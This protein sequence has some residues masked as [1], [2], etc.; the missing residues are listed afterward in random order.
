[1]Q[2]AKLVLAARS[3]DKLQQLCEE[4]RAEGRRRGW[5]NAHAPAY[6]YLDLA[7]IADDEAAAHA[8]LGGLR[9]GGGRIDVVSRERRRVGSTH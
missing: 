9:D 6:R 1:M 4:L 2:G 7:E 3:I 5:T 8:A